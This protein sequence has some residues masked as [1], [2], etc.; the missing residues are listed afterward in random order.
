MN[1]GDRWLIVLAL[2]LTVVGLVM[3]YSS[4]SFF[5][6]VKHGDA[7]YFLRQQLLR[8]ALGVGALVAAMRLPLPRT[9]P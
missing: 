3:V 6:F 8:I 1:R 5:A 9:T 2:V 4:G 7:N